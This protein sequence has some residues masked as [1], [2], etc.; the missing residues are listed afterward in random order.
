MTKTKRKKYHLNIQVTESEWEQIDKFC[1]TYG[2][3]TT[4]VRALLKRFFKEQKEK[5]K[6]GPTKEERAGGKTD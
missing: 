1:T 4:L 2:S 3:R 5:S 6:N